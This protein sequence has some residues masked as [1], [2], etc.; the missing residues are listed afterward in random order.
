MDLLD[1]I[2]INKLDLE[3]LS[4]NPN[5]LHILEENQ[6]EIDLYYLSKKSKCY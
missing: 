5:A 3:R 2:D 6:D 1:R 4:K